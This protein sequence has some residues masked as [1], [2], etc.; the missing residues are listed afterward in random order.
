[1]R[2][3]GEV[4]NKVVEKPWCAARIGG[5]EFV[6]LMP[7]AEPRDGSAMIDNIER[8]LEV[9]NQFYPGRALSVA[10]GAAARERGERL[11]E[12]VRRADT[13]MYEA[14][15]QHYADAGADRSAMAAIR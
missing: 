13:A 3:A 8:L 9:N 5:D 10:M 2:R 14:K 12:V 7:G 11:E 6:I 4:L 1:L 15:R